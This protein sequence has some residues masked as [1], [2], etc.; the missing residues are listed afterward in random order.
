V[1]P[2][3]QWVWMYNADF[4]SIFEVFV[5]ETR[6]NFRKSFYSVRLKYV[7]GKLESREV[8][9]LRFRMV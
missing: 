2:R 9:D 7:S 4:C 6:F 5:G 3:V 1:V 8:H